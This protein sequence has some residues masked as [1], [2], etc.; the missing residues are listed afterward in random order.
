M[1]KK[2][3]SKGL[4]LWV[5]VLGIF[6]LVSTTHGQE[7]KEAKKIKG[8]MKQPIQITSDM[9][10]AFNDKRLVVFSGNAVAIQGD[11]IIRSDK[12]L[13]YYKKAASEGRP[14]EAKD[15]EPAGDLERIEAKGRVNV[16]KG[17][18]VATG[19]EAVFEQDAQKI[20]MTGNAVMQEGKSVIRGH[21]ITLF[22]AEDRGIVEA[23][24]R[25]RVTATI[26]PSEKKETKETKEDSK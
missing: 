6:G 8:D 3:F 14:K 24:E 16:T 10:E 18:R 22:M 15:V 20:V 19:D 2:T 25:K 13:I 1:M 26:Y 12:L 11:V 23:Q 7:A 5:A 9:L 21:K 4:I 17:N